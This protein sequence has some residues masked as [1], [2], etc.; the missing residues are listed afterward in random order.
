MGDALKPYFDDA[1]DAA[2]SG[3]E[4][5]PHMSSMGCTDQA[6][7]LGAPWAEALDRSRQEA[8]AP[9]RSCDRA[10][11][12]AGADRLDCSGSWPKLRGEAGHGLSRLV[13]DS[14]SAEVCERMRRDG[15]SVFPALANTGDPNGPLRPFR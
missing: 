13:Y 6:E 3:A 5:H 12:Q 1:T 14:I 4:A 2:R 10:R 9:Q 15:G 8:A 11:Q 7:E